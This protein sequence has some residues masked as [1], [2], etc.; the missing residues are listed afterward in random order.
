MASRNPAWLNANETRPYPLADSA[1]LRSVQGD[2]MPHDIIADIN[3]RYPNDLGEYPYLAAVSVTDQLVSLTI[4]AATSLS[5]TSSLSPIAAL[6]LAKP[7]VEGRPYA[8]ESQYPGAGG[9][10]VFGSGIQ[11]N[12]SGRFL[13]PQ[14]SLLSP[15]AARA[16]RTLPVSSMAK[17]NA[18]TALTGLVR[19][20]GAA[21]IE[22]VKES[23][24]I[25]GVNRDVVVFRL[26]QPAEDAVITGE[27]SIFSEFLG[28]CSARPES[29]NCGDPAPI[30]FINT[31]R[32][33]CDGN[34][35]IEFQGCAQLAEVLDNYG[36]LIDCELGLIDACA[37]GTLAASD[38][39]LRTEYDDECV[40]NSESLWIPSTDYGGTA[41]DTSATSEPSISVPS[42]SLPYYECFALGVPP[43]WDTLSGTFSLVSDVSPDPICAL[44]DITGG[45]D[46]SY[47]S[48]DLARRNITLWRGFDDTTFSRILT[49]DFKI[50]N[51]GAGSKKNAGLI[52]NHRAH[53][54]IPG[55]YLYHLVEL[56][57]D[58]GEL[59]VL[60]W[61]G[62]NFVTEPAFASV[63]GISLGLWYRLEIQI[64]AGVGFDD[65]EITVTLTNVDAPAV[66]VSFSF[67]I[68]NYSQTGGYFGLHANRSQARF[69]SIRFEEL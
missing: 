51:A 2:R 57:Y 31:V 11:E 26:T 1:D 36:V 14:R 49:A 53:P 12:F 38:G 27:N 18:L 13:G 63:P 58:I 20:S 4:Q 34:I 40:V 62:T 42:G 46:R 68:A 15:R 7:L 35:N 69:N 25:Q 37:L 61:N 41:T 52:F 17:L 56:D 43:E 24:T 44:D 29:L 21:P 54:T 33:D 39:K 16:Y 59:R 55:R 23:R 48:T 66:N 22:V 60:R 19:L 5:D 50:E 28:K 67:N 6:G 65:A 45:E 10:V 30:E 47:E 32:P 8:L 64:D 9:W 3:I